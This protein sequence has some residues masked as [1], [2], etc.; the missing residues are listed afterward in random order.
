[1]AHDLDQQPG[2]I[3]AGA[4]AQS[5]RLL[6]GLHARLHADDVADFVLHPLIEA[7]QEIDGAAC[8]RAALWRERRKAA[9]PAGSVSRN[10]RSSRAAEA[11]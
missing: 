11:S 6:A 9:G 7:D 5:E 8:S 2:R 1:M 4:G 10:G 3:A